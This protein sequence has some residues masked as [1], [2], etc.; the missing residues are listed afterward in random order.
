[1]DDGSSYRSQA[2]EGTGASKSREH[3]ATNN[4]RGKY[5]FIG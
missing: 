1:M 3:P 2:V 5:F 4:N